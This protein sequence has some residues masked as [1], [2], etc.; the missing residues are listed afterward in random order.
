[1]LWKT[2]KSTRT[3]KKKRV[4]TKK[5]GEIKTEKTPTKRRKKMIIIKN[6]A[7]CKLCGDIIESKFRHDFVWCRCESI[8]VDGGLDYLRR[9][10]E[11]A[12]FI[13]LSEVRDET[14]DFI[15]EVLDSEIGTD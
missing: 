12:N 3:S 13:D 15:A 1:M 8:F 9:G 2:K 6:S 7:K 14:L 4:G 5:N 11:P 10:G